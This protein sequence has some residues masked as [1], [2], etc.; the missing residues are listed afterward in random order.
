MSGTMRNIKASQSCNS[1]TND[2]DKLFTKDQSSM[3][4]LIGFH[5]EYKKPWTWFF[6]ETFI[7]ASVN[8]RLC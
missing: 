3:W 4:T 7:G 5:K 8:K 1:H 6:I 2:E